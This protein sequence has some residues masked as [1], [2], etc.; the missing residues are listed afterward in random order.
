LFDRWLAKHGFRSPPRFEP[1]HQEQ[2]E[3]ERK[4]PRKR[5]SLS[6]T[7][8][9]N[10]RQRGRS[11]DKREQAEKAMR[12]DIEE[13]RETFASLN[14]MP[15]KTLVDKYRRIAKR[16]TLRDARKVVL[17]EFVGNSNRDK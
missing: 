9:A 11:P 7:S 17:S 4:E 1:Q 6:P 5:P 13:G 16:T 2:S 14:A 3:V 12:R 10:M 8:P 15:D